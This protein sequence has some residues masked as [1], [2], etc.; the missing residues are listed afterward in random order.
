[1]T[2]D[3]PCVAEAQTVLEESNL[4]DYIRCQS[5]QIQCITVPR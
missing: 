5:G 4:E 1:M 2:L 3:R